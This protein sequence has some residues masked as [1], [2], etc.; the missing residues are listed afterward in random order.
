[1][2]NSIYCS[3]SHLRYIAGEAS[4]GAVTVTDF[5]E[6]PLPGGAMINGII[7][8]EKI[9]TD[10][11]ADTIDHCGLGKSDTYI[12]LDA[13]NIQ[14]KVITVPPLKEPKITEFVKREFNRYDD[15]SS[16]SSPLASAAPEEVHDYTVVDMTPEGGGVQVL[17]VEAPVSLVKPYKNTFLDAG[18]NLKGINIG[19]NC[20][21]K[22]ARFAAE[23]KEGTVLLSHIDD[24]QLILTIFSDGKYIISN[25]YRVIPL[26]GTPEW[27]QEVGKNI[28]SM[29]QFNRSQRTGRELSTAYFTGLPGSEEEKITESLAYLGIDIKI[30]DLGKYVKLSGKAA[31]K[32]SF[33][34][35]VYVLNIG[36]LLRA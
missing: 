1:M 29:I 19:V 16:A 6:I 35:G 34:A 33:D 11:L 32:E 13:N 15:R 12:V 8:D 10:F 17:G 22:L 9:M 2:S 24:R 14:Y 21:I 3:T 26:P 20:Y 4:K 30:L 36:N 23:L 18:F 28:S 7:T 27:I 25:R 5:G 31:G